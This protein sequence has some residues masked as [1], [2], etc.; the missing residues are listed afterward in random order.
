MRL[1]T[2]WSILSLGGSVVITVALLV[3][4]GI[5]FVDAP[6]YVDFLLALVFWPV[7]ICEHLVGPGPST[8]PPGAHMHE[9]TPVHML[10]AV[11]GI[12][13]SWMFWSSLAFVLIRIRATGQNRGLAVPR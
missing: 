1:R 13:F 10:A 3:F 2:K 9:G 5:L 6:S 12:A 4:P 7:V 8:G 11:I